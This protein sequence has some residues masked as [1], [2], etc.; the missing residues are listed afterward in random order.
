MV[1]VRVL[2]D[3]SKFD[4]Y[5][6][7]TETLSEWIS[8]VR[9]KKGA[10]RRQRKSRDLRVAAVLTTAIRRAETELRRKQAERAQRWAQVRAQHEGHGGDEWNVREAPLA[11]RD[12]AHT[13][14]DGEGGVD[15]LPEEEVRSAA[16]EVAR[17]WSR[18]LLGLDDLFHGL[19]QI[20]TAV[21]R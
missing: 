19:N 18:E 14:T 21:A 9:H 1:A 12:G 16:E 3:L 15:Q 5:C 11:H 2:G 6:T 10:I 20:K 4:T 17:L 7:R 8:T 13:H